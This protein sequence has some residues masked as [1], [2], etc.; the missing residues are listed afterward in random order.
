MKTF[1]V[2]L[3]LN[4]NPMNEPQAVGYLQDGVSPLVSFSSFT[5]HMGEY[6]GR[7]EPTLVFKM[8]INSF[9]A[10]GWQVVAQD[11]VRA[12]CSK[13]TQDCIP[14]REEGASEDDGVLVWNDSVSER[15]YTFDKQYFIDPYRVDAE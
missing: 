10:V 12:M 8:H 14:M 13:F 2:N 15:P 6:D 7:P 1:V 9:N 11:I 3:G 5:T 4:N